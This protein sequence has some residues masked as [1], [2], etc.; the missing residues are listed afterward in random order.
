MMKINK[1]VIALTVCL[2][3]NWSAQAQKYYTK[4]GITEFKGSVEA[5]EPVEAVNHNTTAILDIGTGEVAALVFIKSFHF[6]VALMEEHFNENYMESDQYPKATFKGKIENFD[7]NQITEGINKFKVKGKLAM[8]GVTKDIEVWIMLSKV[9]GQI[10]LA[11]QF[12]VDPDDYKIDIPGIVKEKIADTIEIN[13]D[14]NLRPK[15]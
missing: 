6:D 10:V 11:C 8:H 9:D 13:L 12:K 15:K 4:S 3:L 14:Y 7:F 1:I 5:F 2:G